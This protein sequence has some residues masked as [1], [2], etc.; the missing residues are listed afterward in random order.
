MPSLLTIE[1]SPR[2]RSSTSRKLTALFIEEWRAAH[3]NGRVVVRDLA[4]T[5][6]PYVDLPWIGGAFAP[7]EHHSSENA[8]AISV[9]DEL[10]AELQAADHIV[11]GTAEID[12][13]FADYRGGRF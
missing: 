4:Q 7:P 9:S 11:I 6:L 5:P 13:A 1:V 10:V 12:Q 3:P 8:A 2:L